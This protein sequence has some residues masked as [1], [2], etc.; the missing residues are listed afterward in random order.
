MKRASLALVGIGGFLLLMVGCNSLDLGLDLAL[1]GADAAANIRV[2]DGSPTAVALSL[3]D[4]LNRT[5]FEAV[6]TP[7]SDAVVIESKAAS[8]QKFSLM[9]KSVK[10]RDG[11]EQTHVSM[12][13]L[14]NKG[15]QQTG[16]RVFGAIDQQSPAK[17]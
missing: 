15:D 7:G 1:T 14:D 11:H 6:I 3:K 12:I 13:W 2:L 16:I 4:T 9:L 10:A 5:G 8:G 17:K